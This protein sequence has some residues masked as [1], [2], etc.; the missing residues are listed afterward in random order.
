[1]E[2]YSDK[3]VIKC[4]RFKA[5]GSSKYDNEVIKTITVEVAN[6]STPT[7]VPEYPVDSEPTFN[8][9]KLVFTNNTG[10]D[11]RFSGKFLPYI[12]EQEEAIDMYLCPPNVVDDYCHW[13]ENPYSIKKGESMEFN[14]TELTHYKANKGR[15]TAT[16]EALPYGSHFRLADTSTWPSGIA[17]IKFGVYAYDRSKDDYST[18]AAMIHAVPIAESN[19]LLKEGGVYEVVLD[20]IKD[21]A[22]LD[23]SWLNKAYSSSDKYKYVIM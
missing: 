2:V 12:Q 9:I 3:V 17:A 18:G 5:E 21:N 22:T 16:T 7:A 6:D 11:I 14:I 4:L 10:Q 8:G 1:M 19:C 23:K 13:S 20:K 15:L